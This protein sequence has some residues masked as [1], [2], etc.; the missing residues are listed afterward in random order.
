[1]KSQWG[2]LELNQQLPGLRP[3]ASPNSH[4]PLSKTSSR[5]AK[6][7]AFTQGYKKQRKDEF[8]N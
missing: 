6:K 5:D 7:T 4:S 1:V 2:E 3:S 8:S